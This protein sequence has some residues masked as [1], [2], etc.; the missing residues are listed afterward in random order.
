MKDHICEYKSHLEKAIGE[1][2]AAKDPLRYADQTDT[3]LQYWMNVCKAEEKSGHGDSMKPM[4]LEDAKHWAAKMENADGTMGGH[5]TI[6]QTN[7]VAKTYGIEFTHI[8]EY[9]WNVTMNMMYSDYCQVAKRFGV[10][11]PEFYAS[12]A[13]AFLFDKDG[14]EP[15]GKI[16]A[17]YHCIVNR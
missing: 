5:W 8:T 6:D 12:M 2:M 17:Y 13:K 7:S 3:L 16:A 9:C 1:R 15:K 10:D 4:T 14:P 11:L